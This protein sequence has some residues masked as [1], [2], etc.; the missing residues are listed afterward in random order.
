MHYF[1]KSTCLKI[2]FYYQ[3]T[4]VKLL[5]HFIT[6]ILGIYM[7]QIY[8]KILFWNYIYLLIWGGFQRLN[9][10]EL[11]AKKIYE[12]REK[13]RL[14]R[15]H[16]L[17]WEPE[18]CHQCGEYGGTEKRLGGTRQCQSGHKSWGAEDQ[19][20]LFP[21]SSIPD[22]SLHLR[23]GRAGASAIGATGLDVVL[24]NFL[25]APRPHP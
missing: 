12:M 4:S 20:V 19:A 3:S 18:W 6:L 16:V 5:F 14:K 13:S 23:A 2:I 8:N 24:G 22:L 10:W 7:L 25:W 15:T 1:L 17:V 11:M 9:W 21:H